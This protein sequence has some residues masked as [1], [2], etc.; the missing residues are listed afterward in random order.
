MP[1]LEQADRGEQ[2]VLLIPE[3]FPPGLLGRAERV[4]DRDLD[5]GRRFRPV[6]VEEV[7]AA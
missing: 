5:R 2:V 1:V 3:E 4:L 7:P 6:G